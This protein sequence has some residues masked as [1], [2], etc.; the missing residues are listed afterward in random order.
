MHY[1]SS[2]VLNRGG[3]PILFL[4][5]SHPSMC[6]YLCAMCMHRQI[7]CKLAL[8]SLEMHFFKLDHIR[9]RNIWNYGFR[10]ISNHFQYTKSN[11]WNKSVHQSLVRFQSIASHHIGIS[12]CKRVFTVKV[13]VC[14]RWMHQNVSTTNVTDNSTNFPFEIN[15]Q[16]VRSFI[17]IDID[18]SSH[19][20]T[21]SMKQKIICTDTQKH[22]HTRPNAYS[23]SFTVISFQS[24]LMSGTSERETGGWDERAGTR[25]HSSIKYDE[26]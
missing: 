5:L 1:L 25:I 22:M 19:K 17:Y 13:Y 26:K 3:P 4:P 18:T 21:M 9:A 8:V 12:E 2:N 11:D 15:W 6:V 7:K 20:Q 24:I 10:F 23:I 16:S 14:E